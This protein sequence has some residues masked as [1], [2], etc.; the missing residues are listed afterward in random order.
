M[1]FFK[2]GIVFFFNI[3]IGLLIYPLY[4][5]YKLIVLLKKNDLSKRSN[6]LL[7]SSR[8][9]DSYIVSKSFKIKYL[10]KNY[11]FSTNVMFKNLIIFS[12]SP[13]AF[14][15]RLLNYRFLDIPHKNALGHI[16]IEPFFYLNDHNRNKLSKFKIVL[17]IANKKL[18]TLFPK[19]ISP[20][21]TI[22]QYWKQYFIVISS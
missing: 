2:K 14:I 22:L 21:K 15:F 18:F 4:L 1:Y 17:A 20:N 9:N 6:S 3:I 7:M 8:D 10:L 12:F 19:K 5:T 13:I 11:I 16:T